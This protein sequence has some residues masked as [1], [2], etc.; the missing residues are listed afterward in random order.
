MYAADNR[1]RLPVVE[2]RELRATEQARRSYTYGRHEARRR[3]SA[4][5]CAS[6]PGQS[7]G[8]TSQTSRPERTCTCTPP[9]L[10]CQNNRPR[11]FLCVLLYVRPEDRALRTPV[12]LCAEPSLFR[13]AC[14]RFQGPAP[15]DRS[16]EIRRSATQSLLRRAKSAETSPGLR[17]MLMLS[18][19]AQSDLPR[20]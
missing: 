10:T 19:T 16:L 14:Q 11:V 4:R 15:R 8:H 1:A 13:C 12:C 9:S 3:T 17:D 2:G 20:E 18:P 6:P 7:W 5:S